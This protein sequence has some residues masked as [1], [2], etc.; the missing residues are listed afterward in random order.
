MLARVPV[1]LLLAVALDA[2]AEAWNPH[3]PA[4]DPDIP[5]FAAS[6]TDIVKGQEAR[7]LACRSEE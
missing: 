3:S 5:R 6:R 1:L 4:S 7:H 2:R